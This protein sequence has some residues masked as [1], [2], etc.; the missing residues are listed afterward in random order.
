MDIHN[1]KNELLE[2]FGLE[3]WNTCV[4][5]VAISENSSNLMLHKK[6]FPLTYLLACKQIQ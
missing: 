2:T 4:L 1:K 3:I 6:L 5:K